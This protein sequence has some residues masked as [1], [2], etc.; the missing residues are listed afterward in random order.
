MA[1]YGFNENLE[2]VPI[3]RLSKT[4]SCAARDVTMFEWDSTALAAAGVKVSELAKYEVVAASYYIGSSSEYRYT[5]LYGFSSGSPEFT[6]VYPST[7]ID[8]YLNRVAASF[9][10][11][12]DSAQTVTMRVT[13]MKVA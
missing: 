6:S 8:A 1:V 3:I 9:Y 10:S 12:D 5:N 2:K 11:I 4:L 13:L 7:V